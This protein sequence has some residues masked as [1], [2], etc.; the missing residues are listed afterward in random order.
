MSGFAGADS[1]DRKRRRAAEPP[2]YHA[3]RTPSVFESGRG[4]QKARTGVAVYGAMPEFSNELLRFEQAEER[5]HKPYFQP[6]V[7]AA[8]SDNPLRV[9]TSSVSGSIIAART[10]SSTRMPPA[11]RVAA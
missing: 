1:D 10:A 11:I 4:F 2:K 3:E 8:S 7:T 6:S 9:S 5:F